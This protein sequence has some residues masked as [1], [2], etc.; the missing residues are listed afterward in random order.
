[1]AGLPSKYAK[2]GFKRGWAAYRAKHHY[3]THK[4]MGGGKKHH[5]KGKRH[6]FFLGGDVSTPAIIQR[7]IRQLSGITPGK[8]LNPVLDLALIIL[9]MGIGAKIKQISPIKNP[10]LSNGAG[11]VV[12]VGG[13]LMTKNR[14]IKLP[15]LGVALQAAISET[16]LFMPNMLPIA[17]DDEVVYLP[18]AED[19]TP[20]LEYS[21]EEDR[22]GGVVDV[23]GEEDRVSGVVDYA[24]ESFGEGSEEGTD[25]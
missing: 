2:M 3:T 25:A 8:I 11:A 18:M 7:P 15:L 22:V 23:S 1:M 6:S 12:G 24:G 16:K 5:K 17:G 9:G 4:T 13:S 14:F 10:H 20:Q 19:E 21:G